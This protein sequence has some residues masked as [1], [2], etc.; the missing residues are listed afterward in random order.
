[1]GPGN[2]ARYRPQKI[3]PGLQRPP[4]QPTYGGQTNSKNMKKAIFP[5]AALLLGLLWLLPGCGDTC[6]QTIRYTTLEPVYLSLAELRSQVRSGPPQPLKNPGKIWIYR[7]YLFINELY[8]GIHIVDNRNPAAPQPLGFVSIPA[9]VDLAVRGNILYADN[10]TNLLALDIS[11]PQAVKLAQVLTNVFPARYSATDSTKGIVVEW[12]EVEKTMEVECGAGMHIG[13]ANDSR[14]IRAN[15]ASGAQSFAGAASV[16]GGSAGQGGSMARFALYDNFLYTVDNSSLKLFDVSEPTS[17]QARERIPVG[18]GI[19]TIFPYDQKLFLGANTGMYIYSVAQPAKPE[20]LGM[21]SHAFACDPV[22]VH[23]DLAYVTLRSGMATCT[24]ASNQLDVVDVSNPRRPRLLRSF[25]MENP[26]GLGIDF[27]SL[28]ICEGQ[29]GLK[30]F[31]AQ[32]PLAIDRNLLA[33][34]RDI[35]AYDV[36]PYRNNLIMVGKDGLYQFDYSTRREL[37]QLSVLPVQRD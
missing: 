32:D 23:N 1:M 18:F 11:D 16:G 4:A 3:L 14:F 35:D 24:R 30:L 28:F 25:P 36:I 19:E 9:N 7:N 6:T 37:R 21:Y 5:L 29:G 13:L 33:Q 15:S 22:V 2:R 17:P 20:L 26:H 8:K 12:K 31:N 10:H 27:P 34:V